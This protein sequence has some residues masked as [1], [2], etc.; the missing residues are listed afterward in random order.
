MSRS[1]YTDDCDDNLAAGRWI[2]AV[3]SALRGKRGQDF[4]REAFAAL[5]AMPVREL[6]AGSLQTATGEYCTLGVV[7]AQRALDMSL[8]ADAESFDVASAFDIADAMAREIMYQNDERG[9]E[10]EEIAWVK[11]RPHEYVPT[12]FRPETAE[13]RW[14]RMREWIVSRIEQGGR[15]DD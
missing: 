9:G 7:G 15:N 8:L 3:N 11:R 12:R 5:D 13:E 1:G 6:S 14:A 2:G 10:Y 4:L